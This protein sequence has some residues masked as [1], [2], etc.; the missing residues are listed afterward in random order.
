MNVP[1]QHYSMLKRSF[2]FCWVVLPV[3]VRRALVDEAA[4]SVMSATTRQLMANMM[5]QDG[6]VEDYK[7]ELKQCL[8]ENIHHKKEIKNLKLKLQQGE[9]KREAMEKDLEDSKVREAA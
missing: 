5:L 3:P 4:Q 8:K 2:K 7:S 1:L 6:S 9:T